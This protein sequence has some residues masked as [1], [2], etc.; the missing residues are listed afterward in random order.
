MRVLLS[1]L[2]DFIE[3]DLTN[4]AL[5]DLLTL[6]G[7]EVDKIEPLPFSF[8]DVIIGEIKEI[9][10]HKSADKLKVTQVFDGT[11]TLQI[12]CGD[13]QV[14]VGMK[15]ALAQV[16]ATLTLEEGKTLKIKKSKLRD[17]DSFGMLCS[18]KE[19]G[20]SEDN[21][22]ILSLD[23]KAPVGTLLEDHFGDTLIEI[24]LTP[25]L[26]H[27]MSMVG[28]A[29]ELGALLDKKITLPPI[30]LQ[31]G[32]KAMELTVTAVDN[33]GCPRYMCREI[34]NVKVGP[35]PE[36]M[37]KRLEACGVRSI[38]N[39]VDVT[40]YVMLELGQPLH[41]FDG[42]KITG[43]TL[44]V[45]LSEKKS[46][47]ETLDGEKRTIPEGTLMI[48]DKKGPIAV[49]GV[50][51]GAN[52]EVDESTKVVLLECAAFDPSTV[53]RAS[54]ALGI[55]TES[56]ARFERGV[57]SAKASFAL[58]RAAALIAKCCGGTVSKGHIDVSK[59]EPKRKTIKVDINRANAL[60]GTTLSL[61]EG[62]SF[63]KRLEMEVKITGDVMTVTV[64]TYRNDIHEEIDLIEEIARMYGYNNI[65][66]REARVVLSPLSHSPLYLATSKVRREL[67][68]QGL[69]EFLTCDLISP[70]LSELCFEK[71]L[72]KREEIAVLKPSSVDQSILRMSLLPGLL[73]TIGWNQ[74]RRNFDISAFELGRVHFR[75]GEEVV[76]RQ[77]AALILTGNRAPH[78]WGEKP[79][80]VDFFDLKGVVETLLKSF[81]IPKAVFAPSNLKSFHPGK[82]A[83]IR[84]GDKPI[85]VIGEMHPERLR[86]LDL[87]RRIFYAEIDVHTLIELQGKAT[88]FTPLPQYPGSS[89]DWTLTLK[90]EVPI[91]A[92]MQ[93]FDSFPSKLLKKSV[94]LDLYESVALGIDKKNVTFRFEYCNARKT[95][96]QSQVD[97][98]HARLLKF[99][100][101][102]MCEFIP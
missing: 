27:C 59:G 75:N 63:L 45:T 18:G 93:L 76:E 33:S 56:S 66:K 51:G 50:M 86:A 62:E 37:Q 21:S 22:G 74:D 40:N 25:N 67:I 70:K 23:E 90:K 87:E 29:R 82:Q 8:K 16:G 32:E 44:S 79:V 65:K 48:H 10:P 58:D 34:R 99:A 83:Q 12:V 52:S 24:S 19:L 36:W 68:G 89:R 69:Q 49:A 9:A 4:D 73:Q 60:L 17:V 101:E 14:K 6:A 28:I 78:F 31:E 77:S 30:K 92:V 42:E 15:V 64:P 39:I 80:E 3:I 13:P 72:G 98:E 20:L 46:P 47:F 26:G 1:W 5:S 53:R 57:D 35:S 61:S 2:K 38:N 81:R 7:L 71:E 54:K 88:Q 102:R 11:E 100:T 94:L 96:E 91:E 85:G 84:V 95:L 97:K 55:R 43:Q 41:A